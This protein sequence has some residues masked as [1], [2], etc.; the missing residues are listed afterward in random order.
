[1]SGFGTAGGTAAS[2]T[3][4]MIVVGGGVSAAACCSQAVRAAAASPIATID[5]NLL[6]LFLSSSTQLPLGGVEYTAKNINIKR[7]QCVISKILQLA[8]EKVILH[9]LT[10]G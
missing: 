8:K 4:C 3:T 2:G 10:Y 5:F 6:P 9:K 7:E 1:M